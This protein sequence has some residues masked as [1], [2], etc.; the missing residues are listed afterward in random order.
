MTMTRRSLL[1]VL[2]AT[3]LGVAGGCCAHSYPKAGPL[4]LETGTRGLLA[5]STVRAAARRFPV[6]DAHAHFFNGSD[7]PVRGFVSECLGHRAPPVAQPL[8]R[9]LGR[10]AEKIAERAP[11]AADELLKLDDLA[12]SPATAASVGSRVDTE[13]RA[14]A[15][16]VAD[17]IRDSDFQREYLRIKGQ[18]PRAAAAGQR[19]SGQMQASDVLQVIDEAEQPAPRPA[20]LAA[21]PADMD[22]EVADGLLAFL[23]YMV[24]YRWVNLQSYRKAYTLDENA[25]GVDATIG[26]LVDF[27]YWL[28]CPP[29]SGHDDQ[30]RVHQRL[31]EMYAPE[32]PDPDRRPYFYPVVAYNPWTD[33]TQGGAALKRVVDA[34][35]KGDFVAAK[36]YPPT[37]FRPGG[38]AAIHADTRKSRPDLKKLDAALATFFERCAELRIPV[39]AHTARSNGRDNA[40]DE[41][42]GPEGWKRV[43][44][45]AAS[46]TATPI[47]SF[48]HFGGAAWTANFADLIGSHPRLALYADL[49]YWEEL[50]CQD[51]PDGACKTALTQLKAA[52][53]VP[54][55][56]T[57]ETLVD[58]TM[59]ATDWLMLSQVK[60]WA[61][62]PGRLH[63][64]IRTLLDA[65]D[66]KVAKVFGGNAISCFGLDRPRS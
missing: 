18:A 41:F 33:I 3:P 36:I 38:N 32:K 31:Y 6:I 7:V 11:T 21:G 16:R 8:L 5:S 10:L 56:G 25:F 49:G 46:A 61:E 43:L 30:V 13:R 45:Q 66:V 20:A 53:S 34:C 65:N 42:G 14:A 50:M 57:A 48:G 58:R 59:F 28:D 22:A 15:Q 27:D 62:Y 9:F 44:V 17:V 52:L 55:C 39:L 60:R 23:H 24:S 12:K 19:T 1:S 29:R 51:G 47:L 4:Q 40:H 54:V 63:D 26:A 37:G 35:T 64:S 2:M